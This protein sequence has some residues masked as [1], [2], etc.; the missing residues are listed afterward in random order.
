MV[1]PIIKEPNK[2]LRRKATPVTEITDE[3]HQLIDTMIETMHVAEGVGLAANQI[4]SPLDILVASADGQR[5]KEL[6][7]IN[8]RITQRKGQVHSS[9]GCLS[10]PGVSSEITRAAEVTAEGL[11]REGQTKVVHANGL[12]A[13]ILQHETDHLAGRLYIDHLNLFD[14]KQLLAKYKALLD[15]ANQVDL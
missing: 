1:K 8:A 10:V 13:R 15:A 2:I 5:G 7:L 3:T 4:G 14:R 12:M 6:V 9:E 11:T